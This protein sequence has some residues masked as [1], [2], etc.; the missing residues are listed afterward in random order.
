MRNTTSKSASPLQ[1]HLAECL[2]TIAR[3]PNGTTTVSY[4]DREIMR[5]GF[6]HQVPCFY[7]QR[8]HDGYVVQRQT[9]R[10]AG[11]QPG[12][13][14]AL[15]DQL[16]RAVEDCLIQHDYPGRK[17]DGVRLQAAQHQL[18]LAVDLIEHSHLDERAHDYEQEAEVAATD[19]VVDFGGSSQGGLLDQVI[20]YFK[21]LAKGTRPT[22]AL[23][24]LHR[25]LQND[26][27]WMDDLYAE[28]KDPEQ[29]SCNE[30]VESI[31]EQISSLDES[32]QALQDKL[33]RRKAKKTARVT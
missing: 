28:K 9:L 17:P 6:H 3:S 22:N 27:E 26:L 33:P 8:D 31:Q 23:R 15:E 21:R 32:A 29:Q 11:V 20:D 12:Q 4:R 5:G 19:F 13:I 16:A 7:P 25:W 14:T 18:R 30:L 1:V 24:P 2:C 10:E